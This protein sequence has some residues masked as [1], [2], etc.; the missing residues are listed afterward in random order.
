M[1]QKYMNTYEIGNSFGGGDVLIDIIREQGIFEFL[2]S[3]MGVRHPRAEYTYAEG[4]LHLFITQCREKIKNR[5]EHFHESKDAMKRHPRFLKGMSPDTFLYMCKELARPNIY[6]EMGKLS[7]KQIEK[8][9]N[10]TGFPDHEVNVIERYNEMLVDSAVKFGLLKRGEPYILDFDTTEIENKIRSSRIYY[11][12]KGRKAYAPAV[13]MINNIPVY[14]ENRNGNSNAQ[15]NLTQ[16]IESAL[17]LLE[18]KGITVKL[19]RVDAAGFSKEFTEF[20]GSKGLKYVTRA[21]S[22]TVDKEVKGIRNWKQATIQK[23]TNMIGDKVFH[24]GT[25]ET[26]MIVK[27]VFERDGSVTHW[28]LIT[29]EFEKSNLEIIQTYAMRGDCENLFSSLNSFGWEILPMRKFEYNTVY[30]YITAFNYILFRFLKKLISPKMPLRVWE[31]MEL[32][33][34]ARKFMA[35]GTKWI[36]SILA[37]DKNR[38]DYVGLSGF[39]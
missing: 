1:P 29:N 22:K 2:D 33:T 4:V 36:N 18:R 5:V 14:V 26:R 34:F 32:G 37:F 13:A 19:I 7:A 35:V 24:F 39:T 11:K 31:E 12:G 17:D 20:V 6:F 28:S 25:D 15:F 23:T 38:E 10:G 30:L 16:S 9:K 3:Y 21:K 8:I 27:K